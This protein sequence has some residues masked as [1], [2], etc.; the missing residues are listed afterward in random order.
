MTEG[1]E[2]LSRVQR[3]DI[4]CLRL[5]TS[6]R[7]H[8]FTSVVGL[9]S[10]FALLSAWP[11]FS[12][13]LARASLGDGR[14]GGRDDEL[15]AVTISPSPGDGRTYA[16]CVVGGL[17]VALISDPRAAQ[18]AG[19]VAVSAGSWHDTLPGLAHFLEHALFLG[20]S[21]FPGEHAW[22]AW[23][24]AAGGSSNAF[25]SQ[26]ETNYFYSVDASRAGDAAARFGAFFATPLLDADAL[27]REV[28]AVQ[29]EHSK[30]LRSDGWR[31][32]QLLKSAAASSSPLAAFST[33]DR[34][35]LRGG[36]NGTRAHLAAL[37]TAHYAA[38]R[39]AASLSGPQ[40][41][42]QLEI[43]A[44]LA[45]SGVRAAPATAAREAREPGSPLAG[46][47]PADLAAADAAVAAANVKAAAFVLPVIAFPFPP[48]PQANPA[49]PSSRGLL[50]A[51]VPEA[52]T[53]T[54][55]MVWPIAR[56]HGGSA[57]AGDATAL[58]SA[59]LS[60]ASAGGLRATLRAADIAESVTAGLDLD[61]PP[62]GL[63]TVTARLAPAAVARIGAV[64]K[65][66]GAVAGAAAL[67]TLV[68]ALVDAILRALDKIEDATR[69]SARAALTA[70]GGSIPASAARLGFRGDEL[71]TL[72]APMLRRGA[73]DG[74]GSA[75]TQDALLAAVWAEY[76]NQPTA[77]ATGDDSNY[78]ND[79][80]GIEGDEV[81]GLWADERDA[82]AAVWRFPARSDA[83]G[84]VSELAS[85][86]ASKNL[87]PNDLL[88][89]PSRRIWRSRNVLRVLR[90]LA[91]AAVIVQLSSP[92]VAQVGV[93]AADIE[94]GCPNLPQAADASAA[95]ASAAE[96]AAA[97]ASAALFAR[98]FC[99]PIYGTRFAVSPLAAFLRASAAPG[100]PRAATAALPPRNTFIAR[101]FPRAE[102]GSVERTMLR[103]P[104]GGEVMCESASSSSSRTAILGPDV[105]PLLLAPPISVGAKVWA[106]I[107]V[108]DVADVGTAPPA[109]LWWAPDTTGATPRA[110]VGIDIVLPCAAAASSPRAAVLT[111]VGLAVLADALDAP[112]AALRAAGGDIVIAPSGA[113]GGCG[114]EVALRGFAGH[115]L[116]SATAVLLPLALDGSAGAFSGARAAAAL[117]TYVERAAGALLDAPIQRAFA[118]SNEKVRSV[119]WPHAALLA[120]AWELATG[121][122]APAPP[123]DVDL[124]HFAAANTLALADEL[125]AHWAALHAR[126]LG[127]TVLVAGAVNSSD[128]LAL[129]QA[130]LLP[131]WH[132]IARARKS[133][134][135]EWRP[136]SGAPGSVDFD[137]AAAAGAA[138]MGAA[139]AGATP[140]SLTPQSLGVSAAAYTVAALAARTRAA[141]ARNISALPPGAHWVALESLHAPTE[142]NSATAIF[143]D[144]G[145]ARACSVGGPV[146]E[147]RDAA[148]KLLGSALS[149][150]A[151]DDLR[152]RRALG[153]TAGAGVRSVRGAADVGEAS[154]A[155]ITV[156]ELDSTGHYVAIGAASALRAGDS[157]LALYGYVQGPTAPA[158][159][160]NIAVSDFFGK[161]G[162]AAALVGDAPRLSR[163]ISSLGAARAAELREPP[164]DADDAFSRAWSSLAGAPN[165]AFTALEIGAK[166]A[167]AAGLD[168]VRSVWESVTGLKRRQKWS[169]LIKAA[170]GDAMGGGGAGE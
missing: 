111:A 156:V 15:R 59:A 141:G 24:A 76:Q 98:D 97:P 126:A 102:H 5:N 167:A 92:L 88:M 100:S 94:I 146:C 140:S 91:P 168:D 58:L 101:A 163:L 134:G 150:P 46:E 125:A 51:L 120:A 117:T 14:G 145:A 36:T 63:F 61:A 60:D 81:Y 77:A 52:P 99:E 57:A 139:G 44:R 122:S 130:A 132:A 157:R 124:R 68:G 95:F 136:A 38:P 11:G 29:S 86:L 17:R 104:G 69:I 56:A 35:T 118:A 131:L 41:I 74:V 65:T 33:G 4:S 67:A 84:V 116:T 138:G 115:S 78:E 18:A 22:G 49:A 40:S 25:T 12:G 2:G 166:E 106:D 133:G 103:L 82:A 96:R 121:A 148:L 119:P 79:E 50:Y 13:L 37:F 165:F 158:A 70:T 47:D 135:G 83:S 75:A 87:G 108:S 129:G 54:L 43:I 21:R 137:I 55:T 89:P 66:E 26:S 72:V 19:A 73:W 164:L 6:A 30:N 153:Y 123:A 32:W 64:A 162:D 48:L 93:K 7:S 34:N 154:Y 10:L 155:R 80:G 85:R 16:I 143:F 128:A 105:E 114:F 152:T 20:N 109:A 110:V 71:E 113:A 45:F 107:L 169:V 39:M 8:L 3:G 170:Q 31:E 149:E 127:A 160:L 142:T 1:D 161:S 147:R 159:V 42:L 9:V 28:L 53:H 23:V 151:F 112:A 62:L 144:A 27:T 90:Q